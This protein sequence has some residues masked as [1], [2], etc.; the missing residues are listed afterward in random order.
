MTRCAV[1]VQGTD[2]A[3]SQGVLPRSQVHH[4]YLKRSSMAH[5]N[6]ARRK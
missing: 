3:T 4:E 5:S 6:E 2:V 1:Y